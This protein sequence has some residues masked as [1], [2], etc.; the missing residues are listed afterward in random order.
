MTTDRSRLRGL[1]GI[2][3]AA[4]CPDDASLIRSVESALA[5]GMRILQYRD[6]HSDAAT[7]LRQAQ[8]L[9]GLCAKQGALFIVN[10]DIELAAACDADG[11]HLGGDDQ[12]I[13]TARRVL[14][15][16]AI[17]GSSCYNRVELAIDAERQG[18]DYVAFGRFHFS[19]TK[20]G[21]V[22]AQPEI[23]EQA[24][25]SLSVPLCAIGGITIDNA[26]PLVECGAD[27]IAVINGLF[28][29]PDIEQ[30]A[31]EFADFFV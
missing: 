2:T 26:R 8:R 10:D 14:G 18:A 29:T 20:P 12:S 5:G 1:Y 13:A 6:K 11:V 24:R 3:D 16:A 15:D 21:A 28:A 17:I 7:R 23:L 9:K 4:L 19:T 22:Q 30:R 27:M 31:R 25:N